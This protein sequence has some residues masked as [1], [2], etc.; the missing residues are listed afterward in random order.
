MRFRASHRF[1]RMAPRKMRYV[2]DQVRGLPID[3]ALDLLKFSK[4]RAAVPIR[5]LVESAKSNA[6][7]N[8]DYDG[9][10]LHIAEAR[11]DEGPTMKRFRPRAQGR[12]TP[13]H[14]RMSHV[15]IVLADL[16]GGSVAGTPFRSRAAEVDDLEVAEVTFADAGEVGLH[17]Q[18]GVAAEAED[19]A[20]AFDR[21]DVVDRPAV[22]AG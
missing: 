5:K 15:T 20:T 8:F 10:G 11:V 17:H 4:K 18:N 16:G 14:K 3:R 22:I 6:E 21:C 13:I 9:T 2:I 1:I 19:L 12:A 7:H